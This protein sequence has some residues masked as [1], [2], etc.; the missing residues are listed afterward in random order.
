[1]TALT[2]SRSG[3]DRPLPEWRQRLSARDLRQGGAILLIV[4]TYGLILIAGTKV[5]LDQFLPVAANFIQLAMLQFT[6]FAT[7]TLAWQRLTGKQWAD[8]IPLIF[9]L[10][11]A[12]MLAGLTLPAFGIFKQ[13]V[14]PAR[15]FLWDRLIARAGQ[16]LFLGNRAWHL[17]H[18]MFGT[19]RGTLFLDRLYDIWLFLMFAFPSVAAIVVRRPEMRF[20]LMLSWLLIWIAIG[21]VAAWLLASAGPCYYNILIGPDADF[22]LLTARLHLLQEQ[23]A[24]SGHI[25]NALQFQP[26]LLAAFRRDTYTPAGGISAMPSV[27]VAMATLFAIGG[28]AIRRWLGVALTI[29]ALLIWIASIHLGWHYAL[30]GLVA[31]LLALLVWRM[32]GSLG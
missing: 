17:T 10:A 28:F 26:A 29:Y 27:H 31:T 1:M 23:A 14:L 24:A 12:A 19:V 32:T 30:D 18:A 2:S 11:I 21:S 4:A 20:R 5:R 15:G 7:G 22:A 3:L 6:C 13:L 8:A 16:T 25:I 9:W